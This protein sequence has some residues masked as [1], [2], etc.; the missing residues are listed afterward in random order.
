[1][2]GL[3]SA[4]ITARLAQHLGGGTHDRAAADRAGRSRCRSCRW[5]R[6][7]ARWWTSPAWR[8]T[9][10]RRGRPIGRTQ[11]RSGL[12]PEPRQ[13]GVAPLDPPPEAAAS[14]LHDWECGE[15]EGA[16]G[17]GTGVRPAC[18]TNTGASP[19]RPLPLPTLPVKGSKGSALGGVP[20]GSAPWWGLGRSPSLVCVHPIALS[21]RAVWLA[22]RGGL[23]QDAFR[24]NNRKEV[25]QCLIV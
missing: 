23:V 5:M 4:H 22:A 18:R 25:I 16:G 11:A 13:G 20:R 9:R 2:P 14:G 24:S 6:R 21:G 15:G 12:R 1:M 3:H 17:R 19:T 10:R 8:R 7:S